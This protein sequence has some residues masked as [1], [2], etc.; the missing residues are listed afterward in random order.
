MLVAGLSEAEDFI[1]IK[2]LVIYFVSNPVSSLVLGSKQ[3]KGWLNGASWKWAPRHPMVE[4]RRGKLNM[5]AIVLRV[6][7]PHSSVTSLEV[8]ASEALWGLPLSLVCHQSPE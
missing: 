5:T 1:C 2:A 3:R 4:W 8:R 6:Q 7:L